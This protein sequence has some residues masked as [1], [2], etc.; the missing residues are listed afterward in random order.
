MSCYGYRLKTTPFL[1]SI[2]GDFVKFEWAFSSCSYTL[3]S[4]V[5]ILTGKYPDEHSLGLYQTTSLSHR[6]LDNDKDIMIQEILKTYGYKTY[7]VFGAP[8]LNSSLGI[9]KGFDKVYECIN[10]PRRPYYE[11]TKIV[12]DIIKGVNSDTFI[13]VHYF[14]VHHPYIYGFKN[15]TFNINNYIHC[16][17]N[18]GMRLKPFSIDTYMSIGSIQDSAVYEASYDSSIHLIDTEIHTLLKKLKEQKLYDNTNIIVTADHGELLGEDNIFCSHG[19]NLHPILTRVPLLIKFP[20]MY[21]LSGTV[22]YLISIKSI[23]NIVSDLALQ[24]KEL[25]AKGL[26][27]Y[28]AETIYSQHPYQTAQIYWKDNKLH[29]ILRK[30]YTP[31]I[32]DRLFFKTLYEAKYIYDTNNRWASEDNHSYPTHTHY[33]TQTRNILYTFVNNIDLHIPLLIS[34]LQP[35][36]IGFILTLLLRGIRKIINLFKLTSI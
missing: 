13:F 31:H 11:T 6:K 7:A 18:I 14:D 36:S 22:D 21:N 30:K 2:L 26:N 5:S 8:V 32:V 28:C 34:Y 20:E 10:R 1:D 27:I 35:Y 4:V 16:R 19:N 25:N 29:Y 23:F 15:N 12:T 24:A 33:R 3:P 9:G 17:L